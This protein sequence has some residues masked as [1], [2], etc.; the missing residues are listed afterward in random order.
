VNDLLALL[1]AAAMVVGNGFFVAA[2]FALISARRDRVEPVAAGSGPVARAGR[3]VLR[4]TGQLPRMLAGSQLAI[5]VFSLLLGRLGEPA[6]TRLLEQ[7]LRAVG[8]PEGVA[9]PVGFA[10]ALLVVVV[11][12]MVLG[13]TVPR[14]IA[15]AG[16]E[17]AALILVPPL[18][19]FSTAVRP[20]TALFV[21]IARGVLRVLRVRPRDEL[22]AGFTSGELAD[23]IAE[24][25]R[26][27]LLDPA[28]SARLT[29][30]LS[31]IGATVADVLVP[32]D[33]LVSLPPQPRVDDVTAAV[34]AT[35]FS[36]FPV[37]SPAGG[38][39]LGYLHV[40]DVLDLLDRGPVD[41]GPVDGGPEPGGVLVPPQRVRGLPEVRADARLDSAVATLRTSRAHLARAVD[42]R[43][44]T[45][46][47]V[48][49]EDL[50]E[51]FVGTVRDATHRG[52]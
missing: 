15:L 45:V 19:L 2:E 29:R 22:E 11:A 41:G 46:G 32:R 26:E 37:R 9:D 52:V 16:P 3:T 12:H 36:R 30:T 13:E 6:V 35:G 50:V 39:W 27:G 20:V 17:R 10:V 1:V 34:A 21:L 38:T 8:L 23:L 14:N 48:A 47:L 43:G 24:S 25:Q 5:T 40:K 33:E 28:E 31:A 18:S 49:L 4:A 7:P 51:A 44:R 42:P